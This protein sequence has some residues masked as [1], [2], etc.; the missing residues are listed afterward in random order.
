MKATVCCGLF[1]LSIV[2]VTLAGYR[3][4]YPPGCDE[5]AALNCEYEF[6]LCKLFNGPANDKETLC[7]CASDFYGKCLR[8][9]GVRLVYIALC[10]SGYLLIRFVFI[11]SARRPKK[12]A[13]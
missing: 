6:L 1:F 9:A 8:L 11:L 7:N 3:G 5:D 12:W 13:H 4:E 2:Y 10:C